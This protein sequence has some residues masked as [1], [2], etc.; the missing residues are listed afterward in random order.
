MRCGFAGESGLPE[1]FGNHFQVANCAWIRNNY[2]GW[3]KGVYLYYFL[4]CGEGGAY[5]ARQP[6]IHNGGE[7]TEAGAAETSHLNRL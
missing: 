4:F 3:D 1:L 7:G 5:G 6:D 2:L